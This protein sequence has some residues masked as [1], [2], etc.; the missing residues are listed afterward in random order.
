MN[1]YPFKSTF[2]S[3]IQKISNS[4]LDKYISIAGLE[5]LTKLLPKEINLNENPDLIGIV[6]NLCVGGLVNKNFDAI[7]NETAIKIAKSFVYKYVNAEHKKNI[8]IGTICNYGFSKY[9]TNEIL[10]EEEAIK[11]ENPINIS[12]AV[13]LY[14][15]VLSD[16]FIDLLENSVDENSPD[17]NSLS[18]SWE[19]LFK[20][21]DICVGSKYVSEAKVITDEKQKQEYEQYLPSNNGSGKDKNG[22]IVYRLIKDDFCVGLGVGIVSHPAGNVIGLEIVNSEEKEEKNEEKNDDISQNSKSDVILDR[23]DKQINPEENMPKITKLSDITDSILKEVSASV[24]TDFIDSEIDKANEQWKSQVSAKE[25]EAAELTNKLA[26]AAEKAEQ[27]QKELADLTKKFEDLN[28]KV[29]AQEAEQTFNARMSYF[30]SEYELDSEYRAIIASD[31]KNLDEDGFVAYQKKAAV[32]FKSINKKAIAEAKEKAEA[33]KLLESNASTPNPSAADT[34]V[35][36][37]LKNG[38]K[39]NEIPNSTTV[40]EDLYAEWAKEFDP[41]NCIVKIK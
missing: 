37:A 22:N 9:G 34:V 38:E 2:A 8:I 1:D 27:A 19:L 4:E 31:I 36:D 17:Y 6:G 10:T 33:K 7:S 18:F 12:I 5:K 35:E 40:A 16:R 29:V 32:L 13:L 23:N 14:K 24:I 21:Y 11:E 41:K 3:R 26:A 20:N 28:N 30:D 39:T 15:S 25:A